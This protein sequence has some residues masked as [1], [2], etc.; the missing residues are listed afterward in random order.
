MGVMRTMNLINLFWIPEV[1]KFATLFN[2]KYNL[3]KISLILLPVDYVL[4]IVCDKPKRIEL[5]VN[6]GFFINRDSFL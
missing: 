2:K 3:N 4:T 6:Y 5:T 1:R